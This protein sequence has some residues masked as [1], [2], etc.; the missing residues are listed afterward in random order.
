MRGI[1]PMA[2]LNTIGWLAVTLLLGLI[3]IAFGARVLKWLG[4]NVPGTLERALLSA[5]ISFAFLQ[6]AAFAL[7][8]EGWLRR[9]TLGILLSVGDNFR[10]HGMENRAAAFRHCSEIYC[11]FR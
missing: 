3:A 7:L 2:I 1:A 5:G 11:G 6:L 8:A 9:D 4:A 10:R